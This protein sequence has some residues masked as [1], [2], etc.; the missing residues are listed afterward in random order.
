[1]TQ[2]TLEDARG[3][4]RMAAAA[5]RPLR[6]PGLRPGRPRRRLADRAAQR[7]RRG[8]RAA[9]DAEHERRIA[10]RAIA[11]RISS[12]SKTATTGRRRAAKRASSRS[13]RRAATSTGSA[14][15]AAPAASACVEFGARAGGG[16]AGRPLPAAAGARGRA[17]LAGARPPAAL[18]RRPAEELE[19]WELERDQPRL[20][21]AQG[22]EQQQPRP[23][24]GVASSG[25]DEYGDR[26]DHNRQRFLGE[27]GG[28]GRR[29]LGRAE[30]L[31]GRWSSSARRSTWRASSPG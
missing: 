6:L 23:A 27:A 13:P 10:L 9:K 16:A 20:A 28:A 30:D 24:H 26:L 15:A 1:M 22:A 11:K 8:P 12:A 17:R 21:R 25:N 31:G 7:H 18:R 29:E 2:P 5:G 19:D 4:E 3:S 14:P